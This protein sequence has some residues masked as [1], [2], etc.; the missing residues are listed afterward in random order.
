MDIYR[1]K[2]D[3]MEA[4]EIALEFA[5]EH[6][7]RVT[8]TNHGMI[9]G[10]IR[11]RSPLAL[12]G[13]QGLTVNDIEYV[14]LPQYEDRVIEPPQRSLFE[15]KKGRVEKVNRVVGVL[16]ALFDM[17]KIEPYLNKAGNPHAWLGSDNPGL[18]KFWIKHKTGNI[19]VD[20]FMPKPHSWGY[21]LWLRTGPNSEH[22]PANTIA[23]TGRD[24]GGLKPARVEIKGGE[25][26]TNGILR[27][28]E[29]EYQMFDI[30][31]MEYVPEWERSVESYRIAQ[32]AY[33]AK[34]KAG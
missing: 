23:V 13:R 21:I 5:H 8:V 31:E 28:V 25:V 4:R 30:L 3:V 17:G 12:A 26:Y 2:I 24:K 32:K 33:L 20:L 14:L 16:Q 10:S 34:R 15:E 7:K 22:D 18:V 9:A 6:L 29:N 19:K 27:T 1:E 11:R